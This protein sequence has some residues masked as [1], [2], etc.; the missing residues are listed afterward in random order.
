VLQQQVPSVGGLAYALTGL[1]ALSVGVAPG[2]LGGLLSDVGRR[3]GAARASWTARAA[4]PALR[5]E[6]T[7]ELV[8]ATSR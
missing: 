1:G 6:D 7:R 2:G 5:A 8:G 3:A 4:V